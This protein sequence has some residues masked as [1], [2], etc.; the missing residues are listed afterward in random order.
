VQ[1]GGVRKHLPACR[2]MAD[3]IVA[4]AVHDA[5]FGGGKA[6]F[7]ERLGGILSKVPVPPTI[8]YGWD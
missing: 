2:N 3:F 1:R 7:E 6:L 8:Q 4:L 5:S